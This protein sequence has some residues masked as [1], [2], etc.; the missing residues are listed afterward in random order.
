MGVEVMQEVTL[1][2]ADITLKGLIRSA[3]TLNMEVGIPNMAVMQVVVVMREVTLPK[4]DIPL[5][6]LIRSA[7]TLNMEVG[8]LNTAA[9]QITIVAL[10]TGHPRPR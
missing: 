3:V 9:I 8:I 7:V 2:K 5:K 6:G 1:P 4:A 10:R